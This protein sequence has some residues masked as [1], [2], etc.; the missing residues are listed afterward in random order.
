MPQAVSA[1]SGTP[2]AST[3]ESDGGLRMTLS[4]ET[5]RYS[6]YAPLMRGTMIMP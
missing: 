4:A 5:V 6:A 3:W 1:A 2:A